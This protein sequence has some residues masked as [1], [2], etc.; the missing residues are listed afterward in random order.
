MESEELQSIEGALRGVLAAYGYRE[1]STPVLELADVLEGAV[2]EGFGDL[3]RLFDDSGRVLVLRP[4]MTVPVS[5][6]IATRMAEHPGPVRVFYFGRA[7]RPPSPGAPKPAE[8]RQA[9][10]ELVGAPG[11]EADAEMIALLHRSLTSAGVAQLTIAVGDISLTSA[12]LDGAGVDRDT[13]VRLGRALTEKD[14][15]RWR[16]IVGELELSGPGA[17]LV[18]DLPTLRGDAAMLRDICDAVPSAVPACSRAEAV[19]RSLERLG[20]AEDVMIDIGIARDWSY[21]SGLV[22]EAHAPVVGTALAVGGRYDALAE[23]FGT[24][25]PS[26]GFAIDLDTL[27]RALA[28]QGGNGSGRGAGVVLA[29]GLGD[30]LAAAE[31]LRGRGVPVIAIPSDHPDP[32]AFAEADGW[33][34]VATSDGSQFTVLDRHDGSERTTSALEEVASWIR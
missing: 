18:R 12:L 26:V 9:G 21:Y 14:L 7:F 19:F 24:P 3:F 34:F 27:H 32:V 16:E 1:V 2:E 28:L 6:L 11:P 15:V 13:R 17:E 8:V 29:G 5:R 33:R 20:I 25:R 31:A 22:L 23:R 30:H 10:A 4:D